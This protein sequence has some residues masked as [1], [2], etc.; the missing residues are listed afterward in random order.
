LLTIKVKIR[1]AVNQGNTSAQNKLGMMYEKGQGVTKDY[2]QA[3]KLY[4]LAAGKGHKGAQENLARLKN[5]QTS[6]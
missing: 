5:E 6:K 3:I 2:A 1:T 4:T